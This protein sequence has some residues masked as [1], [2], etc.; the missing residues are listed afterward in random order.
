MLVSFSVMI[1]T[2]DLLLEMPH[3]G[4]KNTLQVVS[5]LP[6]QLMNVSNARDNNVTDKTAQK[7]RGITSVCNKNMVALLLV[8]IKLLSNSVLFIAI[9]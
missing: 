8:F 2:H 6:V 1:S 4:N 3:N 7:H 9:L 5:G